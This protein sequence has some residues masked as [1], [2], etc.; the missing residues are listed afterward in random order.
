MTIHDYPMTSPKVADLR[1]RAL[2]WAV[3]QQASEGGFV[4]FLNNNG[5]AYPNDPFSNRLFIG[6]KRVISVNLHTAA[7]PGRGGR[8][9][10]LDLYQAHQTQPSWLVGYLGYDLKNQLENLNSR[11]PDRLGFPD[12]YFVEPEWAIDFEDDRVLLHGAGNADELLNVIRAHPLPDALAARFHTS[13]QIQCRVTPGGYQDNVR[14]IQELIREGDVYEL[15]YCLEFFAE[16]AHLDPLATYR[17]L[18]ERSPMPFSS[19]LKIGNRYVI[20]ASPERF[21]KKTGRQILSQ[22]IKGTIRR[23][24]NPDEDAALRS[25]LLHSEKERAENLMIVDLVRNDLARSAETGSVRVDELFEVYGFRQVY[26]MISTV[27]ATVREGITWA[28]TL[29]NA[30]PMGSMTG[31]PKIRAMERIDE[32]EVS[33]RGVYSGSIGYVTPAGDFDFSVVI[34]SLLYNAQNHYASF[35]VGSAITYDAD[36]AQEWTECLLK[37]Q[38]IRQVLAE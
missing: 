28:D 30:F 4:A 20:G 14:R 15:N 21:L 34:R 25:Q 23:G 17:A 38:P 7:Q 1:W 9:F 12:A 11:N 2:A 36:P 16:N 8:D 31:A 5:I 19:F 37:A 33:R 35:S 22:P 13:P 32:L 27:S 29:R 6:A 10:F 26:Q 3:D 24:Q 18:N